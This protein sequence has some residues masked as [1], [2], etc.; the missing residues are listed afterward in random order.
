MSDG[1]PSSVR[2]S[3]LLCKDTK[4]NNSQINVQ[5]I[6]TIRAAIQPFVTNLFEFFRKL[7]NSCT[8]DNT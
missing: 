7:H 2:I 1:L 3:I 5:K 6:F 8:T 4:K